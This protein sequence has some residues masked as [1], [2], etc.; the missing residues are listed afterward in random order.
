MNASALCII[1]GLLP[2]A[3][4]LAASFMT[5]FMLFGDYI[6]KVGVGT[7]AV[8][9]N[10]SL[11]LSAVMVIPFV[12]STYGRYKYLIVMFLAAAV[13]LALVGL[14]PLSSPLHNVVSTTFFL[15]AFTAVLLAGTKMKGWKKTLSIDLALLCFVGL[16]F[17]NPFIETLQV[18]AVG[19]WV[20]AV[21]LL[22][23]KKDL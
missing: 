17:F 22:S 15:L 21:G 18:F 1:A 20:A 3:I 10:S 7:L 16:A 5:N 6:S 8:A 11:V 4:I 23:M 2:L 12:L 9:F 14:F 13:S 19:I